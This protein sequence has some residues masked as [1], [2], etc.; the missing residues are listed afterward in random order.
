MTF[1]G[2]DDA[3]N[4]QGKLFKI[5]S[6]LEFLMIG[7]YCFGEEW[8]SYLLPIWYLENESLQAFG[9]IL[10]YI[11]LIWIFLAQLQ[12]KDSWRIGIDKENKTELV[13]QGLF[14]FSRNPI[15]LGILIADLGIFFV[16]PNAI[17][18]LIVALSYASIQTQ[19]RLE[20]SFLKKSFGKAYAEYIGKVRRW[21]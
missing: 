6:F 19:I 5:I 8:Y 7:V 4:F 17:S 1:D 13:T 2:S 3:H 15:F 10:L 9:W 21:I 14:Q 18:L 12:M 11:S 16:I 20:E